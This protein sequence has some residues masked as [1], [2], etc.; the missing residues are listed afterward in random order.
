MLFFEQAQFQR[1]FSYDLL[2]GTRLIT[3]MTD[4]T[5]RGITRRIARKSPFLGLE[6]LLRSGIIQDLRDPL[7]TAQLGY[8]VFTT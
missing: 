5:S 2:Q 6:K 4:F 8:T 3:Q 1:L 7:T